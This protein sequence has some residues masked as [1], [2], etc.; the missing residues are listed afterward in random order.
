M[1]VFGRNVLGVE[2]RLQLAVVVGDGD[3]GVSSAIG[4]HRR[5]GATIAT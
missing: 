2:T 3:G 5:D 4:C 1:I